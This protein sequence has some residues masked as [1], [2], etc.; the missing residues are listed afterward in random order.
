MARDA[1]LFAVLGFRSTH[2][3]LEAEALL[4]D[5]G[6]DVTP[7]PTPAELGTRC[8]VALRLAVEDEERAFMYLGDA[9]VA[10]ASR[11]RVV[12]V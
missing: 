3:A 6:I 9:G 8:G 5:V 10:P 12:D 2:A 11:A 1:H 4:A 7:I